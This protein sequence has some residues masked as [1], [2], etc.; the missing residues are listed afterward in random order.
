MFQ[1]TYI[2]SEL[3]V[4]FPQYLR[5]FSKTSEESSPNNNTMMSTLDILY[6]GQQRPYFCTNKSTRSI[7]DRTWR[8]F[9]FGQNCRKI[10]VNTSGLEKHKVMISA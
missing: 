1:N 3:I 2:S 7:D 8:A 9:F 10:G 4:I 5:I 6:I